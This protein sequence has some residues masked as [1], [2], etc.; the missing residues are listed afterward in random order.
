MI[1]RHPVGGLAPGLYF[2]FSERGALYRIQG[3]GELFS[4]ALHV[5]SRTLCYIGKDA[6]VLVLPI[7]DDTYQP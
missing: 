5:P 2:Y 7:L 4:E 6:K 3:Q 1:T